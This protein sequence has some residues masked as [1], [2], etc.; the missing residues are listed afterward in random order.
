MLRSVLRSASIVRSFLTAASLVALSASVGC[1]QK[2]VQPGPATAAGTTPAESAPA[3]SAD[4]ASAADAQRVGL[5]SL[6]V[7]HMVSD[8]DAF[9][10]YFEGG[11]EERAKAGIKGH[12]LTRLDN[13][14]VVIHLFADDAATVQTALKSPEMQKY[15]NRQGAPDSSLVWLTRDVVV[16]LPATP[17]TGE[18]YSLFL[19]L[20]VAD[21]AALERGFRERQPV[22][23]E[24]GVIAEGLH[25]STEVEDLVVLHFVGIARDKLAA[26]PQRKEFVELLAQ[27][28]VQSDVKPL[29]GVDVARSRPK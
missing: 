14:N 10:T 29:V 28:K 5:T 7:V 23:A 18:T 17:A 22:F 12:L 4:T 13:G 27:A 11:A 3:A 25:R 8:F 19:K 21:F 9:K 2:D 24:Q 6:F 20:K 26:L 1:A 16:R 15:I